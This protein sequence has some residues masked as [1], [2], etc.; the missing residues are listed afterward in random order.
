[1][2]WTPTIHKWYFPVFLILIQA[3]TFDADFD[4]RGLMQKNKSRFIQ[5]TDPVFIPT[6]VDL[7][8]E[9][10]YLFL[11]QDSIQQ[12][13]AKIDSKPCKDS[14]YLQINNQLY[15]YTTWTSS[16]DP[17]LPEN[18]WDKLSTTGQKNAFLDKLP[19]LYHAGKGSLQIKKVAIV[20]KQVKGLETFFLFLERETNK[21]LDQKKVQAAKIAIK[22][23]LAF[24]I[25]HKQ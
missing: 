24:L 8:K 16:L 22:D 9:V 5:L 1:M 23:F 10:T 20:E 11:L 17:Y 15:F 4:C 18:Y 13:S 21:D 6:K 19:A 12:V 7:K 14:L 2:H 25:S 3:C